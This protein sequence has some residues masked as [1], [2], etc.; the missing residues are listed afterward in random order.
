MFANILD[1]ICLWLFGFKTVL[2]LRECGLKTTGKR[3]FDT[4][5]SF[6]CLK[7][8]NFKF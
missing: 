1:T 2:V 4:K 8:L 7:K 6:F 5:A 3:V